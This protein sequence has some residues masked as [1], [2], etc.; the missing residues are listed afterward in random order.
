MRTCKLNL[1]SGVMISLSS[2]EEVIQKTNEAADQFK[3]KM[4]ILFPDAM[5]S[6]SI[7]TVLGG[8]SLYINFANIKSR[9]EAPQGIMQNVSSYF[10][11]VMDVTHDAK[12]KPIT[13][14]VVEMVSGG[15]SRRVQ[16]FGVK[17]FRKISAKTPTEALNK[18]FKWFQTNADDIKKMPVSIY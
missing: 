18:T 14:F 5:V 8:Q 10:Q 7:R 6:A 9:E 15:V 11:I 4:G 13:T 3:N 2:A 1:P 12:Y 17:Q 16:S